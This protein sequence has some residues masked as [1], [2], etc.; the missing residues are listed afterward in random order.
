MNKCTF[1]KWVG[2]KTIRKD[3]KVGGDGE[4]PLGEDGVVELGSRSM[5]SSI[6]AKLQ[7]PFKASLST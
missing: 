2:G 1:T 6:T 3:E 5:K 4:R 7:S